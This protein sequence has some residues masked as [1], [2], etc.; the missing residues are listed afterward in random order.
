M[1]ESQTAI[2]FFSRSLNDE[3]QAKGFGLSFHLFERFY[4]F[5]QKKTLSTLKRSGLSVFESYSDH[6]VGDSFGE[7][8]HYDLQS[9][10]NKGFRSV[11]IVGND[12]P[13]LDK[14]DLATAE[15]YLNQ[16]IPV[17]GEDERGGAYLMAFPFD[18][19]NLNLLNGIEWHS[20]QVFKQLKHLLAPS[21]ELDRKKDL[22]TK[23]DLKEILKGGS[24]SRG[25]RSF[26]RSLFKTQKKSFPEIFAKALLQLSTTSRRGPPTLA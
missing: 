6:Q 14:N 23:V 25:V 10:K 8:L 16:G 7:R 18:H 2:L 1:Q 12:T 24:I 13:E 15:R 21:Y 19:I 22:N 17:L 5:Q 20:K 9:I 11:I 26:F 3:F 4:R